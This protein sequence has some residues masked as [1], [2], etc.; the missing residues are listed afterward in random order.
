M[1]LNDGWLRWYAGYGE[2]C[3]LAQLEAEP[4]VEADGVGVRGGGVQEWRFTALT[5]LVGDRV[6]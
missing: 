4:F 6:D 3:S 2:V 5:Y 1:R